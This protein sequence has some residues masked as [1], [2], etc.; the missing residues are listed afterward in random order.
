MVLRLCTS[1]GLS[2]CTW[3]GQIWLLWPKW[4]IR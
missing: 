3:H 4:C 1:G 2:P